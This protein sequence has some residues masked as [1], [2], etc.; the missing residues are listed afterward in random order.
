MG[1]DNAPAVSQETIDI[2]S[3]EADAH[4]RTVMARLLGLPVRGRV[5]RRVDGAIERHGIRMCCLRA[6]SAPS[7]VPPRAA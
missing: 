5:A 2:I 7:E 3:R 4:P 1:T 6:S